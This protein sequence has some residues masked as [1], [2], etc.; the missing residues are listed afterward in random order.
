MQWETG[1]AQVLVASVQHNALNHEDE[2][3]RRSF[4]CASR[5]SPQ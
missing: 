2:G 4:F 5:S 3:M 1:C